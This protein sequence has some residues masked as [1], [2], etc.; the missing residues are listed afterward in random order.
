MWRPGRS[1]APRG[2]GVSATRP[3]RWMLRRAVPP[4]GSFQGSPRRG[5]SAGALA[6]PNAVSPGR[7]FRPRPSALAEPAGDRRAIQRALRARPRRRRW[8]RARAPRGAGAHQG[9][10]YPDRLSPPA[11]ACGRPAAP[12]LPAAMGKPRGRAPGEPNR[13]PGGGFSVARLWTPRV[14]VAHCLGATE[15]TLRPARGGTA[16]S[17]AAAPSGAAP[18]AATIT[19]DRRGRSCLVA[20]SAVGVHGDDAPGVQR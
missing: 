18:P 20:R 6:L 11:C 12:H 15:G 14:C 19:T 5:D 10:G 3:G 13:L 8:P 17:A 1:T 16:H 2:L 9:V 7:P 4:T